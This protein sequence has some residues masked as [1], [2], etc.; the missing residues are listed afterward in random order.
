MSGRR[1]RDTASRGEVSRREAAARRRARRH[2]QHRVPLLAPS[3]GD[4]VRGELCGGMVR[5]RAIARSRCIPPPSRTSRA[6]SCTTTASTAGTRSWA[7]F[8]PQRRSPV[9]LFGVCC[10]SSFPEL[11]FCRQPS[12]RQTSIPAHPHGQIA[13]CSLVSGCLRRVLAGLDVEPCPFCYARVGG[14]AYRPACVARACDA[15]GIHRD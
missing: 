13:L 12:A 7:R 10:R 8:W 2:Q 11:C 15:A 9:Q 6:G 14:T 3:V 4:E 1:Q 5:R